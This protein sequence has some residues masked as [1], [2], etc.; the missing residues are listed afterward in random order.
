MCHVYCDIMIKNMWRNLWQRT[1]TSTEIQKA[2]R[3]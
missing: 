2:I 1:L 3:I